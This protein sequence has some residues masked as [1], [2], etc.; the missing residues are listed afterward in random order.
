MAAS[1]HTYGPSCFLAADASDPSSWLH[2]ESPPNVRPQFFYTSPLPIDDPLTALPPPSGGQGSA[3][4]KA[5][6]QPYSVRDNAALEEAWKSL[7]RVR[8]EILVTKAKAQEERASKRNSGILVPGQE[9]RISAEWKKKMG[10]SLG[11]S[12][13]DSQGKQNTAVPLSLDDKALKTFRGRFKNEFESPGMEHEGARKRSRTLE[14]NSKENLR[15]TRVTYKGR[16]PFPREDIE[17]TGV[18][19]SGVL[20]TEDVAFDS[21]DSV[22]SRGNTS[23]DASISGSPFIRAPIHKPQSLLGRSVES[24]SSRDAILESSTDATAHTA[25]KRSGLRTSVDRGS[26]E[27]SDEPLQESVEI[28]ETQWRIPVGASRLHLVEL[29]KLKMKPI[30]WS[31][32]H[33]IS[34]V[35]RATWFYK[36]TMLPVETELANKLE[37]GYLYLQPWTETWQDELNSCVENGADAELKVVHQL[38]AKEDSTRP[39]TA[40]AAPDAT[41]FAGHLADQPARPDNVPFALDENRAAGATPA[42]S[43]SVKPFLN[44]SVIYADWREA[45]ILRPSLLPSVSRGRR[46]LSAIR[47]GRQIGIPVVRG[48][49]RRLWDRLHPSKP[50]PVEV[51]NYLRST[52][53]RAM[54]T[55][56]EP[57]CYACAIEELR[58][59]PTDLVL[60]IHGI[61]QK[62]SER[63][64]SFHF[65]HAIN[66]FRR[67]INMELNS[68]PVWP[69]VRPGHAGIMALPVNWRST[70]SLDEANLESPA[71][72]DPASNHYSLKD[73][74][75][76]TIPAVRSLISDVMLDIPYYL[77]HHK[78]KMIQAVVKEANR[79]FRLWCENNPGF[80]QNGRVHLLAHSLGSAM[81]LDILSHQPTKIPRFDFSTTSV[82]GDI[83][84]FDTKN[85]FICGSPAGF[86]LFLNKANLLPRRGRD[87]PGCEGD[88]RLRGV[89]GEADTYGC[90]AVDNLYNIMHTTDPIA[91]RVNAAVD[92]DLA[93][94]LKPASIPTTTSTIWSSFGNVFRWSS[95]TTTG[96]TTIPPPAITAKLPTQVELE[97]HDFTREEIA[98]KRML[99]LN[100]NGQIDYYLS[101]GGGPLNIQYLN[102]LSAHSS[103]WTL[104]DFVRFVVI[105][106]ARKQGREATLPV[107]RAEKKKGWRVGK[108]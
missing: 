2:S 101:G 51:R 63:M 86:F 75:P 45:Q 33:D 41:P 36:N 6:L 105:E 102:M 80:Q 10:A 98:E 108:G 66:A 18:K 78:P 31:P 82:H 11:S 54:S 49:S 29:P 34:H 42:H 28:D 83:F 61:G 30:Y 43:E 90:L 56:G 23:R 71:T 19:T 16:E 107:L 85:L 7:Q 17:S 72:G 38:W 88:D 73:I 39:S 5:P 103:Y 104:T 55:S 87:K 62:L 74:T 48:F 47:K 81:A 21:G 4:A 37:D 68:E 92:S 57:V 94:S 9:P 14:T 76:E 96:N 40:A 52:Q 67:T 77:S 53:T 91:Y 50:S 65:T 20:R 15:P 97:T 93:A 89:A 84:E 79:I 100:D 22:S 64:E 27:G 59:A 95:T 44:S 25:A 12:L 35:V 46:P 32:L 26:L 3:N 70:L 1:I 58:P 8:K 69:H 106:I 99:L 13:E 24:N 60:V